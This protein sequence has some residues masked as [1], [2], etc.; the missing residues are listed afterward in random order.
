MFNSSLKE[1][2]NVAKVNVDVFE[3]DE[4]DSDTEDSESRK[5]LKNIDGFDRILNI[6]NRKLFSYFITYKT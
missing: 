2:I 4:L 3:E 5:A 1:S 6:N